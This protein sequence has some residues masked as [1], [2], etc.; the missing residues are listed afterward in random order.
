LNNESI[1]LIKITVWDNGLGISKENQKK[2]FKLFGKVD[3]DQNMNKKGIGLGLY[4]CKMIANQFEGDIFL[5]SEL[6]IGSI[7]TFTM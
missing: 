2:L 5:E 3:N 6:N 1:K 7:F 4:I